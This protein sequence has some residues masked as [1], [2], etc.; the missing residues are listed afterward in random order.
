V[1]SFLKDK[2]RRGKVF[3]GQR[4]TYGDAILVTGV[5]QLSLL[6]DQA[7]PSQG[8]PLELSATVQTMRALGLIGLAYLVLEHRRR[9]ASPATHR[10]FVPTLRGGVLA[11][12]I[13]SGIL[14]AI[15]SFALLLALSIEPWKAL[16]TPPGLPSRGSTVETLFEGSLVK[17]SA[18][19]SDFLTTA[20][21][22]PAAEELVFR[23]LLT[24]PLARKFNIVGAALLTSALWAAGH[25]TTSGLPW[26]F[27]AGLIFF[28]LYER[29]RSLVPSVAL[30]TG[31]NTAYVFRRLFSSFRRPEVLWLVG[32]VVAFL[33]FATCLWVLRSDRSTHAYKQAGGEAKI[34]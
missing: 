15:G 10:S 1:E 23:G 34:E 24:A 18:M 4:W 33:I 26:L 27:I 32:T 19:I 14:V 3:S 16:F 8:L 2:A 25:L 12:C 13:A 9:S 29:S 28:V 11:T 30:H 17:Q 22:T 7:W 31:V 20:I 21:L 5:F 6:P